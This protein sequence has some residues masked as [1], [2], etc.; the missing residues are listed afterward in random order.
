VV[1][2]NPLCLACKRQVEG[3]PL[4]LAIRCGVLGGF[5]VTIFTRLG[6]PGE[7]WIETRF[8]HIS[9]A[10]SVGANWQFRP[11]KPEELQG[12]LRCQRRRTYP[13]DHL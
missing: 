5:G 2:P 10:W 4:R 11:P 8:S 12:V 13:S 9:Q 3:T 6:N 7:V 1:T